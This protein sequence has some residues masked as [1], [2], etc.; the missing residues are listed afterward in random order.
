[1][2]QLLKVVQTLFVNLRN[3][4]LFNTALKFQ[5]NFIHNEFLYDYVY[6][7]LLNLLL[8]HDHLYKG[9]F[10]TL[11][12]ML[13]LNGDGVHSN[14]FNYTIVQYFVRHR[15]YSVSFLHFVNHLL[16]LYV[17]NYVDCSRCVG[18]PRRQKV[19]ELVQTNVEVLGERYGEA[20]VL[21]SLRNKVS[22]ATRLVL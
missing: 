19:V 5:E 18:M 13:K 20:N 11:T 21:Q 14:P 3:T 9:I 6:T 7:F 22:H 15:N 17:R 10:T 1:M 12:L 8:V 4:L 2:E 16:G